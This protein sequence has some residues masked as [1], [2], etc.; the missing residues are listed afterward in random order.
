MLLI[1]IPISFNNLKEYA[2]FINK[3]EV[4]FAFKN[5]TLID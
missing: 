2:R 3:Y 4:A 5:H 1:L